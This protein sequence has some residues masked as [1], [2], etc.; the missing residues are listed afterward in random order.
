[1]KH[2]KIKA[3]LGFDELTTLFFGNK[4]P[5]SEIYAQRECVG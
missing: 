5:K 2:Q 3:A 4:I 1:M